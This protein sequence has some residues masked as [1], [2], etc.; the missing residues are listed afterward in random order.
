MNRDRLII[1]AG[2][3]CIAF[4]S[5]YVMSRLLGGSGVREA[6]A[7]LTDFPVLYEP[8]ALR[9]A[10]TE[11]GALEGRLAD[12]L[13]LLTADDCALIEYESLAMAKLADGLKASVPREVAKSARP[14]WA[15][16]LDATI[17]ASQDL[18]ASVEIAEDAEG[19]TVFRAYRELAKSCVVCHTAFGV[20]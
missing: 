16:L 14:D 9:D 8:S 6:P 4:G 20:K 2:A 13:K 7:D 17:K 15:K 10:M 11:M 5:Y 19:E 12:D 1:L 3:A 18:A